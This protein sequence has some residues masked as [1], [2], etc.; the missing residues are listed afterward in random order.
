MDLT[1]V[2][3]VNSSPTVS[4]LSIVPMN[5][6][7]DAAVRVPGS[8]SHTNRAL[9]C[10]ALTGGRSRLHGVLLAD[11]T[12]AMMSAVVELGAEVERFEDHLGP[13]AVVV[14][15]KAGGSHPGDAE[16]PRTVNVRQSGTTGRFLLAVLAGLEGDFVLDGDPQLRS[17][18]FGPQLRSLRSLG[19][20][21][22]GEQLPLAI[23]GRTMPGGKVE[24]SGDISSQFLSGLLLAAPLAS[25][26]T[27]ISVSSS[28][29]SKPYVELTLATMADFGVTVDCGSGLR[30]F[31]VPESGYQPSQVNIEPDASAASY[32]FGA[33]ALAG[34]RIRVAG[35][36]RSTVQGD[37]RFVY[38]LE[39][40]GCDVQVGDD[41]T[42]VR[43]V[44]PLRGIDIDMS[45]ISD[46]VQTLAVVAS[47]ATTATT[48]TGVGFIRNKETDRLAATATELQRLG[49]DCRQTDDG[50]TIS[51][52]PPRPT[53][54]ETYDDHRMAMSF[55]ILGLQNPGIVIADPGCVAKTFPQF[56]EVL[57]E[58]RSTP[59]GG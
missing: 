52:G 26:P 46:T 31:V 54:I 6:P 41:Y 3:L 19:A 15:R 25:G 4:E 7:I 29:V 5:G 56:F 34:G 32:F 16:S 50:L 18:P 2:D 12:E 55:A 27:E 14:G 37:L 33:A 43:R 53:T 49:I 13:G 9:V 17:R 36:G 59:G 30:R 57:D 20:V 8:K 22:D 51:P 28:L 23:T 1:T 11:D 44:G 35:L 48:I 39:Q 10:A 42:E 45:D 40:M 24:V 58:L 47:Q 38:A 21:V